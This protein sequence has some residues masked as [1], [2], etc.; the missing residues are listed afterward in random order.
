MHH[1]ETVRQIVFARKKVPRS[2]KWIPGCSTRFPSVCTIKRLL[3]VILQPLARRKLGHYFGFDL[4]HGTG[5]GITDGQ[6]GPLGNV[7]RAE[8]NDGQGSLD[9]NEHSVGLLPQLLARWW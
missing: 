5:L 9:S 6:C 1:A 7:E 4:D 8:V 2:Q 3:H